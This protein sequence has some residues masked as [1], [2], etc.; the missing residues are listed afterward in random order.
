[1]VVSVT[2]GAVCGCS[3]RCLYY[4][5]FAAF[6]VAFTNSGGII[7]CWSKTQQRL[8]NTNKVKIHFL[9]VL[10][11][12]GEAQSHL[13]SINQDRLLRSSQRRK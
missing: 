13:N 7:C 10:Q 12:H 11:R 1:M 8:K 2:N 3:R 4:Q 9:E 5:P 6:G